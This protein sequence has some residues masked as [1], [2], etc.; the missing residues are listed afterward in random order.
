MLWSWQH[1][2]MEDVSCSFNSFHSYKGDIRTWLGL[3][4]WLLPE[5]IS[6]CFITLLIFHCS[7]RLTALRTTDSDSQFMKRAREEWPKV[8]QNG[9]GTE[10]GQPTPRE[11]TAAW[12]SA[13][14]ERHPTQEVRSA[15]AFLSKF[16]WFQMW[17][18]AICTAHRLYGS[19]RR[20]VTC[21]QRCEEQI[22]CYRLA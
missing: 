14:K 15:S 19:G 10:L 20:K 12:T 21:S 16:T 9:V 2:D 7:N 3:W 11:L 5:S 18:T 13:G 17:R 22:A 6:Q 4:I 1:A 8:C